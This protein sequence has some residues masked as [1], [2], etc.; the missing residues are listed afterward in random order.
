MR[1]ELNGV[2]VANT[3]KK[4]GPIVIGSTEAHTGFD[5]NFPEAEPVVTVRLVRT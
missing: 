2:I 4:R 5:I 3:V 1:I